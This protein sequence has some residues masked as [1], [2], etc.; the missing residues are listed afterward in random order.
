MAQDSEARAALRRLA[1]ALKGNANVA[2]VHGD[3]QDDHWDAWVVV[4]ERSWVAA[5]PVFRAHVDVDPDF[6]L[7][8]HV[9]D[10]LDHVPPSA[11][12]VTP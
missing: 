5:H 12:R 9:T 3:K 4:R 10:R 8:V 2:S 1:R 6:Y 11:W 7:T